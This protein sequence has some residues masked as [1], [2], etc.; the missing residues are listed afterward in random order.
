MITLHYFST[1]GRGLPRLRFYA[2]PDDFDVWN[3]PASSYG[4]ED[5]AA[6]PPGEEPAGQRN[7]TVNTVTLLDANT[8]KI[9]MVKLESSFIFVVS[10]VKFYNSCGTL[11]S[12][13]RTEQVS[14]TT[15]YLMSTSYVIKATSTVDSELLSK[16]Y[17]ELN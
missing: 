5:V 17:S 16:T 12:F 2:V 13:T 10:E 4:Y 15:D 3:S 1:D 9:L 7:V 8:K 6:V 11:Q 14:T